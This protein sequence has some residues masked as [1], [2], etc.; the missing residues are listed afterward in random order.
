MQKLL[1]SLA[2][3]TLFLSTLSGCS[4]GISVPEVESDVQ[5]NADVIVIGAGAG[6]LSTAISAIENGAEKVIIIEKTT[7]TGGALNYTSGSMSGAETII[8][9]LDGV[10]DTLDSFVADIMK[11][12]DNKGNEEL[13]K[14]FVAEDKLA[15]NWLWENGL[16]DNKFTEANGKK[17]LF[18]PEHA[19]YSVERTY[20][21]SPDDKTKYKSAA[22]EVLDTYIKEKLG[23]KIEI[24]FTTEATQLINNEKGQILSVLA[25]NSST[26]EQVLYTANKGIVVATGGYSG[27]K[28][29]MGA[30][31]EYGSEYL[32]G[33]SFGANGQGIAMMQQIG[34]HVDEASMSYIPTFPMGR[35]T[36]PG[37][38][39]IGPSYMWKTGGI[40]VN[41]EGLRFVDET[42]EAV[43][44]REIKLEEQTNAIQYDIFSDKIIEDLIANKASTFWS[45][46][47]DE[48]KV[49][50]DSVVKAASLEELAEKL[51][52][53]A[54]NLVETVNKYNA[55]VESQRTDEFGRQ[56]TPESINTY[57]LA[58]NKIEGE[59]FYAIPLKALC[60][61]T[62]GGV[63]IN[64]DSNVLD[65]NGNAIPGL[66]A[67]GECTNVWGRFVSGGTGV[68][69]PITFGRIAGKAVMSNE[70]AEA[71]EVKAS[72]FVL[73]AKFFEVT[74]E[75]N[76]TSRFDMNTPLTDGT[77]TA[78]VEGQE[79]EMVVE[80]VISASKIASVTV[81]SNN[82]T[83]AVAQGALDSIPSAIVENN[84]VDID[85]ISGA[86]LTSNRILDA[87]TDCLTQASK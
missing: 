42:E 43:E 24:D 65:D 27:N 81:V 84:S 68:M 61:M 7:M 76:P 15:I 35:E 29:L 45:F 83:P 77:Y 11:N 14:A 18:A 5:K 79:G 31:A 12:G 3:A 75:E 20:K 64:T 37:N 80:V 25:T 66:F 32:A 30:Y 51:N 54:E 34:A 46:F 38:G 57:N 10:E 73:D 62:L 52:M 48:G 9:E 78:T 82:E 44:I 72:S 21:A 2:V 36:Q 41:Q 50:S 47:Y 56:F 86:T 40:C 19:L 63:T 39:A 55:N 33:G 58:I 85:T 49:Y 17:S 4:K 13:I 60:V 28:A 26:K 74:K 67:V 23:D 22:H 59:T 53:P 6:G 69:G 87:V 71:K 70:L 16:S 1:K 8:Q